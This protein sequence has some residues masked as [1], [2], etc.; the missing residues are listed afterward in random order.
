MTMKQQAQASNKW[1]R[2]VRVLK[3]KRLKTNRAFSK[4]VRGGSEHV[5]KKVRQ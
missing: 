1:R 4:S 3:E 5:M 2:E